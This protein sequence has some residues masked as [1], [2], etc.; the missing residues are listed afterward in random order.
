MLRTVNSLDAVFAPRRVALV[1]ASD[2]PGTMGALFWRNLADFPGE[3]VPVTP[4]RPTVGSVPAYPSLAS[5]DGPIDLAVIVVPAAA[6]PDVIREAAAKC[7]PAAL[8]I[9]SGFAESGP[10]GS[11]LQAEMMAAARDGGVRIVGPNSFGVQNCDLPLNASMANGLPLGG[12][13]ITLATQSGSYGMAVHTLAVDERTRFAKVCAMGNKADIS[14]AEL[15][16]YFTSD[17]ASCTLCFFLESL[18]KGREFC[19]A[20]ELAREV[21]KPVIVARIGRSPTGI[22]AARSHTAALAGDRRIWRSALNQAGVLVVR[23]GLEM[24]DVARALDFQPVPVGNRVAVITNSGGTGVELA[25]LLDEEGLAVPELTA[26]L[27]E[28]IRRLLPRYA[29]PANPV[30]ITPAWERFSEL[31]PRLVHMLACCGEVDVVIPV[32]VQ[33]AAMDPAVA[34]GLRGAVTRLRRLAVDVPVYVCWVAPRSARANIDLLQG[35]GVPCFEWPERTARAVG[36]AARFGT[37]RVTR[38]AAS[39][40]GPRPAGLNTLPTGQ[41]D[42][43][44]GASLLR[45]FGIATVESSTCTTVAEALCAAERIGYPVVCKVV[46]PELV[47]RSDCGGVVL[48]LGDPDR[49]R[50]AAAALFQ[51]A[52]G[53]RVQVQAQLEGVEVMVGGLRDPQFG[54][55]IMVGLGGIFVEVLDDVAFGLAPVEPEQAYQLIGSLRAHPVLAGCRGRRP[56]NLQALAKTLCAVGDLLIAYP[57]ITELDLNPLVVTSKDAVA[58]DWRL[59]VRR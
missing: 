3:V 9:S 24:L 51:L 31:Y 37:A 23:S 20:A 50:A 29:S 17:P 48:N 38:R 43:D 11:A 52:G 36:H 49:L 2:H 35:A 33:R 53:A 56:V 59:T 1:G 12:G 18:P 30:D 46:H 5:I 10:E 25:D 7:V 57:E 21:S 4:S 32:L 45:E 34:E 13:G 54:P 16:R 15:L 19:D 14:D 39:P 40:G 55:V 44:L 41:L 58:V 8:V 26:G 42:P 28:Q 47:H 22:R 27:Q 6:V